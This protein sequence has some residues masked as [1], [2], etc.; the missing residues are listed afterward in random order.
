MK[1]NYLILSHKNPQQVCRLINRLDDG[2]SEFFVHVDLKSNLEEFEILNSLKNTKIIPERE[3]CIW[4]DFSIV[5]ATLHLLENSIKHGNKGFTIL[6]SGQDYPIKSN[7]FINSFLANHIDFNFIEVQDLQGRKGGIARAEIVQGA[8]EARL[9][10]L[11][12]DP[13]EILVILVGKALGKLHGDEP[14]PNA[15]LLLN[16][17]IVLQ[18]I[19]LDG[20]DPGH[21]H[22]EGID[23]LSLFGRAGR[24]LAGLVKYEAVQVVD[25]AVFLENRKEFA[26][27]AVAVDLGVEPA[28]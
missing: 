20:R 21:I 18:K 1:K 27:G 8:Q 9:V 12:H 2:T 13:G 14:V 10:K 3:K 24:I 6:L 22:G 23:R 28:N 5:R 7:Q 25:K 15:E 11:P 19:R 16:A 4:G 26:G 17:L